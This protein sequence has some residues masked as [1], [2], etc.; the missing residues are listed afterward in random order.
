[1]HDGEVRTKLWTT[2]EISTRPIIIRSILIGEVIV[3]CR[4]NISIDPAL[5]LQKYGINLC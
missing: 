3:I 5:H 1:M 4:R 2:P